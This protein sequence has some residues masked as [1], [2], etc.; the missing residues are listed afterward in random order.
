[1][2]YEKTQGFQIYGFIFCGIFDGF[3]G[4]KKSEAQKDRQG[5]CVPT[6]LLRHLPNG[7]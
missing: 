7:C 4:T 3:F 2:F 1:M 5:F 6:V